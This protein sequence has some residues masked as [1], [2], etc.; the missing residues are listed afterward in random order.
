VGVNAPD[1]AVDFVRFLTSEEMQSNWA[2]EGF[3]VPPGVNAAA[4]AVTDENLL[5]VMDYLAEAGY[6][7]L[8]YDQFLPPAVG[9]VV[10]DESQ[11]LVAGTQTPEGAAEAIEAS[12]AM[13]SEG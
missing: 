13:E 1:V 3:A 4:A 10:N 12:F 2:A 8:Y 9:G 6:F 11:A 7:Q 5:P